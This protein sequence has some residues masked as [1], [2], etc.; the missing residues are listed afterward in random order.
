MPNAQLCKMLLVAGVL[1]LSFI[2]FSQAPKEQA[3]VKPVSASAK[4]T[5]KLTEEQKQAY[6]LLEAS[7]AS[8]RGLE[9]PM[10]SYGLLQ[11][12]SSYPTA[13]N[14]GKKPRAL[15]RDAF[16]SS[17]EIQDDD[18]VKSRLQEDI[19]RSLLP[20]SQADVE[21][22]LSQAESKVRKQTSERMINLYTEKKQFD[23]AVDLVNQ[24]T[25]W[26]EFPYASGGRLMDA[27]P[28]DMMADKQGLFLQAVNSF[29]N[30]THKGMQMGEGT[31]TSLIVRH[32]GEMNPKVV[33]QAIDDVLSQAK[34]KDEGKAN[35]ITIAGAGG[36]V[37]FT[38]DYE[39]QLFSL[40]P[41][42]ER[43]D[44]SRAKSLLQENQA[45]QAKLQQ[46][47]QGMNSIS[48]PS[49][50]RS[51]EPV[52]QAE[53]KPQKQR[54]M[55]R[56]FSS[57]DSNMAAQMQ[58]A[59]EAQHRLEEIIAQADKDPAQALA[60]ATTLPLGGE[61]MMSSPRGDALRAIA[62]ASVKTNAAIASQAAGELRKSVPDMPL[63]VQ[64]Q[65]LHSAI[66]IY[67]QLGDLDSAER[68]ISAGIKLADKLL[69]K[70][71]NPE[72]PNKALKAWWP[73][74][75]AYRRFVEAQTKISQRET[76]NLLKE[77]KD[78]DIRTMESITYARSLLGLPTKRT[79]VAEKHKNGN[80]MAVMDIGN[81]TN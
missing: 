19:F 25:A 16:T 18:D 14:E 10:R 20:L 37:S 45:L 28:A 40:L 47:P 32:S 5:S 7:E 1:G 53:G 38:S 41:I 8:S 24:I 46:F 55:Q 64:A 26:D 15:L 39:F 65:Y 3:K 17:L 29:K 23:K 79:V 42:L 21:E 22:L 57:T 78:P 52:K 66:N 31:L 60:R 71:L 61:G 43:L 69:E 73:S 72:D 2:G 75:D 50:A 62:D 74:T 35:N 56:S 48:P 63:A 13:E 12:A 77:I 9:A 30:H 4:P 33:L 44:E 70:D 81:D 51:S 59:A 54:M 36:S 80:S 58:A 76:T 34:S 11:I 6:D 68:T 67:T 27:L 49:P